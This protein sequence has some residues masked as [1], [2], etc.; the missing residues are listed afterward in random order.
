MM[1]INNYNDDNSNN[2][3]NG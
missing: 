2:V 3:L 1:M